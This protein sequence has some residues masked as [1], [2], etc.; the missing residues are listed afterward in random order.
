M[1]T[2]GRTAEGRHELTRIIKVNFAL[3]NCILKTENNLLSAAVLLDDSVV[4][5][6][7]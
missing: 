6:C 1:S 4:I 2:T 7:P 3:F 5:F